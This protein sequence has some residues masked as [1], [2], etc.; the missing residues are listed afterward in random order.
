MFPRKPDADPDDHRYAAHDFSS[1]DLVRDIRYF[2]SPDDGQTWQ[3]ENTVI[4]SRGCFGDPIETND[5]RVIKPEDG[6]YRESFDL[7]RTWG[8]L[9]DIGMPPGTDYYDPDDQN[10]WPI[11]DETN[12]CQA[13]NGALF[14]FVRQYSSDS[15]L[16]R[17]FATTR[18]RDGGA[19]WGEFAST[20]VKGKMPDFTVLSLGRI[21]LVVGLEGLDDGNEIWTKYETLGQRG[22]ARLFY[23]DDNGATWT[24]DIML[25]SLNS[26][27]FSRVAGDGPLIDSLDDGMIVTIQQA[28]DLDDTDMNTYG[29]S[30]IGNLL[31]AVYNTLDARIL[32]RHGTLEPSGTNIYD[33]GAVV[34]LTATPAEAYQVKAWSGTDYDASTASIN[35]VTMSGAATV[36]VEFVKI[37]Q[38]PHR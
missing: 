4:H 1:P 18:S 14:S 7:G 35:A 37:G 15:Q 13:A 28:C 21:L 22:F 24:G 5:G 6:H 33:S 20:G 34:T 32:G 2:R 12:L 11:W 29:Q 17:V 16:N 38:V 27:P 23:S 31:T 3:L 36:T 30:L 10:A 26:P 25:P 19:T 9:L 8:P